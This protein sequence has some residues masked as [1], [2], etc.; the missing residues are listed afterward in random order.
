MNS[1]DQP[2]DNRNTQRIVLIV[3]AVLVLIVLIVPSLLFDYDS[4]RTTTRFLS[5]QSAGWAGINWDGLTPEELEALEVTFAL[6][7]WQVAPTGPAD[8]AGLKPDD[9]IV[10]LEGA[11]FDSVREFQ[12]RTASFV[13]GQ[14]ITLEVIREGEPHTISITLSTWDEVSRLDIEPIGF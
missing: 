2:P 9:I 13:P 1:S 11:P 5:M 10:A 7:V 4:F 12:G 3:V 8:K 14:T 6:R